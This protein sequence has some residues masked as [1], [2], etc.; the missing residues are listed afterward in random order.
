MAG[1]QQGD[2]DRVVR[3]RAKTMTD[4]I[5]FLNLIVASP[6]RKRDLKV[7]FAFHWESTRW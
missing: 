2:D 7:V 6:L 3:P 1:E 5:E 4:N